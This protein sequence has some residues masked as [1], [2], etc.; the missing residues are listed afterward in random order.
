[1]PNESKYEL[2]PEQKSVVGR[3]L[4]FCIYNKLIVGL[5][6]LMLVGWGIYVAPFD[7]ESDWFPRN[8]VSVDA[9]PDIGENQ[10]IVFTEWPGRSPGDV[11]DQITYPLT[12]ALLGIPDIKTIRSTSM[13]GF[14][15]IY[16][17]FDE[18]SF[19][20][21][22]VQGKD[23]YWTRSRVLEK[24]SSLPAGTLPE[25]VQ[26][27]L[28]PDATALGQIFWYTLEGRDPKGNIT[29]GWD[30]EELRTAQDWQVRLALRSAS[31]VSEVASV[32]GFVREYQVDVDPDA[33]R[34]YKVGI[35]Q[36][37]EAV[38]RSNIDVGAQTIE[39]NRVEYLVR[40]LG[41]VK[42]VEDI[43]NSVITT[44]ENVPVLVKHVAKVTLGPEPRRGALD[45]QGAEAVGGVVVARYGANPLAVIKDVKR[46]IAEL[47]PALPAKAIITDPAVTT[48]QI[49]EFARRNGFEAE[50]GSGLNQSAWLEYLRRTPQ[51]RWPAWLT[52]SQVSVVPFYD[53]AGLIYE[54]LGTLND[55]LYQ[56]ILVT[57][58]VIIVM[59]MH[60][61]SS[62]M[63]S[64]VMPLAVLG[65]FI[66]MKAFSIDANIVS[67][68]GI[69]IAIGTIVDMGI[70]IS[71]NILKH[72]D[73]DPPDMPRAQV[74]HRAAAEVGSAV[75]S[76][77]SST[78]ISFIPVF[79]MTGAEGKLFK[80]LAFTKTFALL[81]SIVV[82]L[83]IIPPAAHLMFFPRKVQG[84]S[85]R[86]ILYLSLIAAAL[87]V[88]RM[89]SWL[90]GAV[91]IAFAL[92]Q[93]LKGL[94][95]R[96]VNAL[97]P[98]AANIVVLVLV[99]LLLTLDWE[100]LGPQKGLARNL[101]FVGGLIGM[102]MTL[103][104]L[105]ERFYPHILRW[106]LNHKVAF[107]SIPAMLLVLGVT[108][109]LGFERVFSF[110]PQE[111]RSNRLWVSARHAFP[112]LGKEFMPPLDEGSFLYMPTTMPHASIGEALDVLQK[113]DIA[114]GS[115]P[116]VDSVVG[117]IGR[118][119][120]ALDPAPIGMIETVITYKSE[121]V[122]DEAGRRI[123]FR[124]DSATGEYP[125]DADGR[126]IPDPRGRPYRQWRN[127]IK[128][129]DDIWQEIVQ[130]ADIPGMT[131]AP[132]L[133]PIAARVV[134]L[135]SGMRAAMGVKIKG[136]DLETIER[137]GLEIER[138]L[139]DVPSIDAATVIADR[140]VGKPY[141]EIVPDRQ[142][143]A[144]Y[145]VPIGR[146]QEVLEVAVGGIRVTTTVEGRQRFPV[147]VRY[148][149][150]LRDSIEALERV[151]IPSPDGAQIPLI[152]V[153]QIRYVRGPEMIKSEDTA[154]V[155]YVLFDKIAGVA[156][157]DVVEAADRLLREREA[158]GQFERPAGVT[159]TFAGTYENQ[160]RASR[161]L[162]VLVPL[163]LFTI[164]LILYMQFRSVALTLLVFVGVMVAWSGAFLLIWLY[165]RDW[166][167]NFSVFGT[168]LRDLFQVHPINLSV[169]VWVGFLALFGIA[170]D[171]G[172]V[173]G[174]Y[175]QQSFSHMNPRT[176]AEIR[177]A[178]VRAGTRRVRAALMTTAT[179]ILALIPVFT[180]TGRGSD[181]MVPM[182]IPSFGGMTIEILTMLI[183][184]V[185]Y[186]WIQE[187][188]LRRVR[189]GESG[190]VASSPG[191]GDSL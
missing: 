25:G 83:T 184:P 65:C 67:L 182:A 103:I 55:A 43:E 96:R 105:F 52:R 70:V 11:E 87:V 69:A 68:A 132:Q 148:Q 2:I 158:T 124:Y 71:E 23:F 108:I 113:Q 34:A 109:W 17:I 110:V 173:M 183:V 118:V 130:A 74:I 6:T 154:L 125:R 188:R 135:Q 5:I 45:K 147:R 77:V 24:L 4:G 7:W 80:P 91:L 75:L 16:I 61:R 64:A 146:F 150:E 99:G 185:L 162:R 133:Q 106:C 35:D 139:K 20:E 155:G 101:V 191:S 123:T 131:S 120:S 169:A 176:I 1:M 117:K 126:L 138:M 86:A 40:G 31:G 90:A 157:V 72:L 9:I 92:Y 115:I 82:A 104:L 95:P 12:T 140:I 84:R 168:N 42:T 181:I 21:K 128:T 111:L 50:E 151:L 14:S 100:P 38:K 112:G 134:M 76:A 102:L 161:T 39:L 59:L 97:A 27:T 170:D 119:E 179:T 73:E 93:L 48:Q 122:A 36:V 89:F 172:V 46:T 54:T 141:L 88:G 171:D 8:P 178:T 163:S 57:A 143:L 166:F 63:I 164:L 56:Q 129:P 107:L 49:R 177:E 58:I 165:G 186:C 28:G 3:I 81:A 79:F 175:L 18:F 189:I 174:T 180:S 137:T 156:E 153:A 29:G 136:P 116:E 37:F 66:A 94:L 152:Q 85:S 145:G 190:Q 159:I 13:F 127:H 160:L 144:R 51:D 32:G 149:R 19:F 10:Q 22:L 60:L 121:Y 187:I 142:A 26:S 78:I 30:L 44:N 167:L 15:S 114:I 33:M 47:A 41:F 53:R 98:Y 62:V